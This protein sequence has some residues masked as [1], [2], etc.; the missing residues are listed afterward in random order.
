[1]R[2][3][4]ELVVKHDRVFPGTSDA[5]DRLEGDGL[6]GR[7]GC[8]ARVED[9]EAPTG[10]ASSTSSALRAELALDKDDDAQEEGVENRHDP[11]AKEN[12]QALGCELLWHRL[13]H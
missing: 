7:P 1:M 6:A 11:D 8:G 4:N 13:A 9:D 5:R 12:N 10:G 2:S 3:R